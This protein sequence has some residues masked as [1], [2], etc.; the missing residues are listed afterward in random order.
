MAAFIGRSSFCSPDPVID[1]CNLHSFLFN[2]TS[3]SDVNAR[4][5]QLLF[6][7]FLQ[8][9]NGTLSLHNRNCS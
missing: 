7:H 3:K 4:D 9:E 6:Y 5:V 8:K 1:L 2:V